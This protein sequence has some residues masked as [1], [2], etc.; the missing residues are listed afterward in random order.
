MEKT[1]KDLKDRVR[2]IASEPGDPG[3]KVRNLENLVKELDSEKPEK[4]P[5][6]TLNVPKDSYSRK[7]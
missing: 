7:K 1:M 5:E 2:Q 3:T 6:Y 4:E